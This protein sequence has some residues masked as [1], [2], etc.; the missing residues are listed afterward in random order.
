M[1]QGFGIAIP[2]AHAARALRAPARYLVVIESGAGLVARLLGA[3]RRELAEFDAA[4]EEAAQMIA[5][6]E[7]QRGA[8][9]AE[10]DAALAG[11][12]AEQ[13]LAAA[14]YTLEP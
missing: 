14:L 13:R 7:P 11:H 8:E 5:G 1:G 6:R 9:G 2:S 4:T 10:W 3:D 12:S